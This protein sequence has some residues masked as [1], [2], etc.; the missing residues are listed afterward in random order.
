MIEE[1][2]ERKD[3]LSHNKVGSED[4]YELLEP[5][6]IL[7]IPIEDKYEEVKGV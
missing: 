5:K 3:N 1:E 2:K 7:K 4:S 6:S